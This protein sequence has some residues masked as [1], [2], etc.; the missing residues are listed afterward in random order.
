ML[1]LGLRLGPRSVSIRVLITSLSA[2]DRSLLSPL[3]RGGAL[4]L[5]FRK[6]EVLERG[7]WRDVV[8]DRPT[9]QHARPRSRLRL[10]GQAGGGLKPFFEEAL[11]LTPELFQLSPQQG[12]L[13]VVSLCFLQLRLDQVEEMSVALLQVT[14]RQ[15]PLNYLLLELRVALPE[16]GRQLSL[17]E[18]LPLQLFRAKSVITFPP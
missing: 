6:I 5:T 8:G 11:V 3:E 13:L 4:L 15:V 16:L 9:A 10:V 7:T 2:G 17:H 18:E 1:Q 12:Y 14:L